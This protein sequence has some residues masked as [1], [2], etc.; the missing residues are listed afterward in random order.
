MWFLLLLGSYSV[1]LAMM[2]RA[3][4]GEGW[5]RAL[6]TCTSHILV[7]MLH[8]VSC[9]YIYCWPF[10]VLPMDIV[11]SIN[12]TVITPMLNPMIYTHQGTRI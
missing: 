10:R 8:F 6:S 3:H 5:K 11:A 7:V 4:S 1:I 9:V 2:L 12:N